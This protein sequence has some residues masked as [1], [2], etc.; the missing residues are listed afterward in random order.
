MKRKQTK[1]LEK[2]KNDD[3]NLKN[4]INEALEEIGAVCDK[5]QAKDLEEI[6]RGKYKFKKP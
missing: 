1:D 3:K 6:K 4:W 5:K 2:I